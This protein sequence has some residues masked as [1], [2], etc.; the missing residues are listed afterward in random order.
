MKNKFIKFQERYLD[1]VTLD[2]FKTNDE[3]EPKKREN[4]LFK[5]K[6]ITQPKFT[7]QTSLDEYMPKATKY[8]KI[9]SNRSGMYYIMGMPLH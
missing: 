9:K 8:K 2:H 4:V 6:D 7:S 3:P 5:T 1:Y